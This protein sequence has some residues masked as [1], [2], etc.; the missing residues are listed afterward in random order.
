MYICVC[1]CWPGDSAVKNSPATITITII[2]CV[3]V[4]LAKVVIS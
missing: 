1:V 2:K 3:C 4:F